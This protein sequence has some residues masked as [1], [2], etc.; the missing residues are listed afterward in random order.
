MTKGVRFCLSYDPLK[1]VFIAVKVN[2]ILIR[3]HIVDMDIVNDA[4]YTRQSVITGHTIY[5]T[6]C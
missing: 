6:Q 1:L 2:L 5:M 3:K 4:T